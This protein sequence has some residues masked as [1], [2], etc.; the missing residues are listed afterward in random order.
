VPEARRIR[1]GERSAVLDILIAAFRHDPQVRWWFPDDHHYADLAGR[2]FGVLLDTRMDGGEVWVDDACRAVS[3]WLPPGGNL[4]GPDQAAR[5]YQEMLSD[6]PE[7]PARRIRRVDDLVDRLLPT[8]P[9]WYLGVLACHP[10]HRGRGLGNVVAAPI[11]TA[12]D[13]A[14]VPVALETSNTRN[15]GYYTRRG[16]AVIG[17]SRFTERVVS[18]PPRV[19][20]GRRTGAAA[21][22]LS[23]PEAVTSMIT[24]NVMVRQPR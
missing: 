22:V 17:R 6:L 2:F 10:D 21:S 16:F 7:A 20:R 4:I 15:V 9:H 12:A 18:V 11:L 14:E 19:P 23:A 24:V 13:R 3:L 1:P 8:G 5:R